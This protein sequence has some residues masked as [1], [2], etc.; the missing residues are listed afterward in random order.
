[1]VPFTEISG[2][3]LDCCEDTPARP[4]VEPGLGAL[5]FET[6]GNKHIIVYFGSHL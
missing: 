4:R 3:Y 1:L 5:G 6:S 2:S